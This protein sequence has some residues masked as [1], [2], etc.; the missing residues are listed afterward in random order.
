M[1]KCYVLIIED[2]VSGIHVEVFEDKNNAISWAKNWIR[3]LAKRFPMVS[4]YIDS[5][6]RMVSYDSSDCGPL[7]NDWYYHCVYSVE[8]SAHIEKVNYYS[9]I[10]QVLHGK[11]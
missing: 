4:D 9:L 3:D 6:T 5:T 10:K 1:N 11:M 2:R 8:S 7:P